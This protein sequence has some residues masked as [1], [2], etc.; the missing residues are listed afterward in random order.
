MQKT[1]VSPY[2]RSI[3]GVFCFRPKGVFCWTDDQIRHL[4]AIR[5]PCKHQIRATLYSAIQQRWWS[6]EKLYLSLLFTKLKAFSSVS[7]CNP[8]FLSG[9]I[10]MFHYLDECFLLGCLLLYKIFSRESLSPFLRKRTGQ[11]KPLL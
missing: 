10:L 8:L 3:T 2:P 4:E 1:F 6:N 11:L 9:T 7:F 5:S